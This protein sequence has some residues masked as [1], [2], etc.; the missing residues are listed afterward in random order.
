VIRSAQLMLVLFRGATDR[1]AATVPACSFLENRF[2]YLGQQ[3]GGVYEITDKILKLQGGRQLNLQHKWTMRLTFSQEATTS[4]CAYMCMTSHV[5]M[6]VY[7][8][9]ATSCF[10]GR[11]RPCIADP[12]Q[13]FISSSGSG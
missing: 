5:A 4:T 1:L 11:P 8:C 13:K 12:S 9:D 10:C 3:M 6:D 7:V 2:G